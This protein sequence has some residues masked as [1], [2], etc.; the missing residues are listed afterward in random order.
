MEQSIYYVYAYDKI[1]K[2]WMCCECMTHRE[3]LMVRDKWESFTDRN[4]V[5]ISDTLYTRRKATMYEVSETGWI[6]LKREES[7]ESK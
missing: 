2:D 7:N 4:R 1:W 5:E 3:A 6:R